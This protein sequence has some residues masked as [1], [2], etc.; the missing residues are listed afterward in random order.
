[1]HDKIDRFLRDHFAA[2][3]DY[4]PYDEEFLSEFLK[5]GPLHCF[6]PTALGGSFD[7]T[8]TCMAMLDTVSYHCLPLGLALGITGSLFLQPMAK[9]ASPELSAAILPRFLGSAELNANANSDSES[10]PNVV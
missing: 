10:A 7:S 6:I 2:A 9:L 3:P 1:M 8:A 4:A 5:L